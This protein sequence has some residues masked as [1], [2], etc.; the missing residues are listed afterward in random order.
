MP[1]FDY[2]VQLERAL[3]KQLIG[4]S[5]MARMYVHRV[6]PEMFMSTERRF[7]FEVVREVMEVSR[8]VL[9][10]T[11]FEYE[12][13]SRAADADVAYFLTEWNMVE[14]MGMDEPPEVL[15]HKIQEADVG[16]KALSVAEEVVGLLEKGD[17]SEAVTHLKQQA[18]AIGARAGERPTV[19]LTDYQHRV[20][21]IMEKRAHPEKYLGMK[22]G[23]DKFDKL[24]GGVF[25]GEMLLLAGVTGLGKS[26]LCRQLAKNI[27]LLNPGK[28]VLHIANEEYQEQVESKYDALWTTVPYGDF[29]LATISDES[30][31][32]WTGKME[33]LKASQCGRIFIKEVPAFSNVTLIEQAYRELENQGIKIDVIIIDHLPHVMPVQKAW[34]ENDERAKAASECKELGRWLKVAII[35]PTQA[36][37]EVEAKQSKGRRAG[38]LD[39][40]GSKGQ[41]HV[42]NTFL[43][44]THK[45]TDDT[46][47]DRP[48]YLRDTYL[49]F[50]IK[51]NRDGPPF[52][53]LVKHRV[54]VGVMEEI[55]EQSIASVGKGSEVLKKV[56]D[57]A[58]KEHEGGVRNVAV[59]DMEAV[60][61]GE[62]AEESEEVEKPAEVV[63]AVDKALEDAGIEV[64]KKQGVRIPTGLL[65]KVRKMRKQV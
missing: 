55:D 27:V 34:G 40:Y 15:I 22:I 8:S 41:I 19:E 6:T 16:R 64:P 65:D 24:T 42:A 54:T 10:K 18:M 20:D 25:K 43:I 38:K 58:V 35:I 31:A 56:A 60:D 36:A 51:K 17:I 7:I 23:F 44:I 47:T 26:T 53:F 32:V 14:N 52:W 33:E 57:E 37:T 28:N 21:L 11:V 48:D 50:D 3:L 1:S 46:Q 49:L 63:G 13:R 12:V 2:T 4:S 5:M 62:D 9:T 45:G 61:G 29:K 39:V 30:M 59:K